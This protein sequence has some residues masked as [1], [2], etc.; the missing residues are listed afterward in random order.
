MSLFRTS[1]SPSVVSPETTCYTLDGGNLKPLAT[2]LNINAL[3]AA[4]SAANNIA[5]AAAA[6]VTAGQQ[7]PIVDSTR[8]TSSIETLLTEK[9]IR[10]NVEEA[11]ESTPKRKGEGLR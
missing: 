2:A 10:R 1:S 3:N 11:V 5:A 4:S 6:A 8:Q 9:N 7:I